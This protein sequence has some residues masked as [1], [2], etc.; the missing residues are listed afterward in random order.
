ML[1]INNGENN[2]CGTKE[3]QV[4]SELPWGGSKSAALKT[5]VILTGTS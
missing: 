2:I 1:G 3:D 5:Q 4:S